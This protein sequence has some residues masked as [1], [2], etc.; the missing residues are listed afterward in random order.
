MEIFSFFGTHIEYDDVVNT[1]KERD[2]VGSGDRYYREYSIYIN[3]TPDLDHYNEIWQ[4]PDE[5]MCQ[6]KAQQGRLRTATIDL[7]DKLVVHHVSA[8]PTNTAAE[9][10]VNDV[11]AANDESVKQ[12]ALN[13]GVKTACLKRRPTPTPKEETPK[14][15]NFHCSEIRQPNDITHKLLVHQIHTAYDVEE[16]PAL[17]KFTERAGMFH[18]QYACP[19][20]FHY[21]RNHHKQGREIFH[22]C[23][24]KKWPYRVA[25]WV[26]ELHHIPRLFEES[27][28]EDGGETEDG[29]VEIEKGVYRKY[30]TPTTKFS[31]EWV[32]P[33]IPFVSAS[34]AY[35][36]VTLSDSDNE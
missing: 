17:Q 20:F 10:P 26:P 19:Q 35:I 11:P 9:S 34:F 5:V 29:F 33:G 14:T 28:C 23:Y 36:T 15:A 24:A 13:I 3:K 18:Y 12:K 1:L 2:Y 16:D 32:P 6:F 21:L 8:Q 22:T 7:T 31:G 25:K 30:I 27:S 4:L